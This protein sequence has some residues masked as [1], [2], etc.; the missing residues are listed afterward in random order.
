VTG[1]DIQNGARFFPVTGASGYD[2]RQAPVNGAQVAKLFA[3]ER[4]VVE[5]GSVGFCACRSSP[6]KTQQVSYIADRKAKFASSLY[7]IQAINGN[8]VVKAVP[9]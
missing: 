3:N 1:Q 8:S 4:A 5:R 6:L 9:A 7:E 2:I